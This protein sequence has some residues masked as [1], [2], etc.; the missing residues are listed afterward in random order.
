MAILISILF[1]DFISRYSV[2]R[3]IKCFPHIHRALRSD[4][5]T[6]IFHP[7]F[8]IED[9]ACGNLRWEKLERKSRF[10]FEAQNKTQPARRSNAAGCIHLFFAGALL[11]NESHFLKLQNTWLILL[12]SCSGINNLICDI[13]GCFFYSRW[14]FEL[15]FLISTWM[16]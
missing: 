9:V 11:K 15:K 6:L 1:M 13:D 12:C 8:L 2:G 4:P 10:S 16:F 7:L 14:I 3:N 5:S